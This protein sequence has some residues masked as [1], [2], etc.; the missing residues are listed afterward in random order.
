MAQTLSYNGPEVALSR[1]L[2]EMAS[3]GTVSERA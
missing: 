2:G 3:Q 1:G